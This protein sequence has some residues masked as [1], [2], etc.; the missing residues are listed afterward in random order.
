MDGLLWSVLIPKNSDTDFTEIRMG[1][2]GDSL[3]RLEFVDKLG[4]H[5]RIE[6]KNMERHLVLPDSLFTFIVPPGVDVI[7]QAP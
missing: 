5:T 6:L 2:A 7:G 4:S 1:F 3:S